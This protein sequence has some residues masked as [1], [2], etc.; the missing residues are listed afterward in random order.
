MQKVIT[1][2]WIDESG[3]SGF[4]FSGGSSK[5]LVIVAVYVKEGK[6]ESKMEMEIDRLKAKLRLTKD[7]EFKFSRCKDDFRMQFFNTIKKFPIEYKA[8]VIDKNKVQAP[9]L[10]H[11]S[12]QLYCEAVRRLLYDNNPPLEKA[13]LTIDETSAKIHHRVFNMVLKR[14]LSKNIVDKIKQARSGSSTMV[15]IADMISG[16]IFRKYEKGNDNYYK[17]VRSKEKILI[18]F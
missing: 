15:Q 13:V 10:R 7:Y 12:N 17:K 18:K 5:I 2:L 1:K 14:Y 3:D 11:N 4:K 16:S 9:A 6:D 8:I